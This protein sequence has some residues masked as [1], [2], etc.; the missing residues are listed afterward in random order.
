MPET[1]DRDPVVSQSLALYLLIAALLLVLSLGWAL[2]DEFFGLRPWKDYQRVFVER[3]ASFLARE[4]PRQRAAEKVLEN[5]AEYQS[6]KQQWADLQKTVTPQIKEINRQSALVEDRTNAVLNVLTTA[7]AYVGSE[8][9]LIEHISNPR[10]KA[11]RS[12]RLEKYKKGPFEVRLPGGPGGRDETLRLTF[13]QL[14]N[15]FALLQQEKGKLLLQKAA[16]LKPVSE[17]QARLDSYIKDHS[18]GLTVEALK[19]LQNKLEKFNIE[20]RQINNP[21]MGVVDRC[22]SCHVGIREPVKLTREDMGVMRG[23]K[24]VADEMSGAFTSHPDAELLTIHDPEKFGCTPC[25]GGNGMDIARVEKAHGHDEHWLW[26]LHPMENVEAGCQQCHTRDMVLDH[27]PTLTSGK[28]LFMWRGCVGCHRFEGY[29]KEPEELASTEREIQQL[30]KQREQNL[31]DIQKDI[32]A[33]DNAPDNAT[34][35]AYYLKANELQVGISKIDLQ[36]DGLSRRTKYLM[37]DRKK[38]GPDLKDV[39]AKLRPEWIPI[40]LKNPHAFRPTTR[41]PRFRLDEDELQAVAAFIWQDALDAKAPPQPKG[42]PVKGKESF[43]TRGCLGCHSVG[44]GPNLKGGWFAANLS[45]VGEKANY[46]YL[47]RWIHNPRER[48]APY[49]PLEKRDLTPDDY[50]KHGLPY[51]FDLDHSK[52]PNDGHELQV[53]QMTPMPNLRLSW[54]ESRDIASYLMTLKKDDPSSYPAAPYLT[55]AKLK[56]KGM[57]VVRRYGCAGCH[58][59][60]GMEDEGRIGTELTKEG[61]K[62][63][64]QMDFALYV[65]EAKKEGWWSHKGFFEHKLSRPE[66]YDDGMIKAEG[67]E[68]KMPDFFEPVS[69]KVSKALPE[70]S[71][72]DRQQVTQLTTFLMGAVDSQYPD[73]YFYNPGGAGADIQAGWWVVK[74]YNCEGCHQFTLG[75]QSVLQTLP[76]YQTPDGKGQ[77]PPRL[78][79]EGARVNPEWLARFLANPALSETDTDRDGVR[80]YL[81]LRM[82]TFYFSP[83]EI[84]ILVRFFQALSQQPLPYIPQKLEP[85]T[86]EETAMARALFT[87]EAAPCLKC[88]AIGLPAHD[89]FATAPNFLLASDRL[90]PDWVRH[91]ILDPAKI[92]PG[93]AMPSGLFRKEEGRWV[94]AGPTPPAFKASKADQADL[95]VRYLL[96]LTPQ[97]QQRLI[98]MSGGKLN[99]AATKPSTSE[100]RGHGRLPVSGAGRTL[101]GMILRP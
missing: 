69:K 60:A 66:I 90:K 74:K 97:E 20:I 11:A 75:Q 84:R 65:R 63:L 36:L 7:R 25:H 53:E 85:L 55:D 26:P 58:E 37:M 62:P 27:A 17:L 56:S 47:V 51:V 72:H 10:S 95:L 50:K 23:R 89:K 30:E 44:E 45:R 5:S 88:H 43:E 42:D 54:Q 3:Y 86:N 98:Q 32:Q 13:D 92:D 12:N 31:L 21:D 77:L 91:W 1:P 52:C 57:E 41:M 28:D 64:E 96:E 83:I 59:I 38:V 40:W 6:L 34:A 67:E 15:E 87:S 24:R 93:T 61:S 14:E 46:D 73:R 33:G 100:V 9:Y 94:F 70:L 35:Q 19:G 39:R 78:L 79:T 18:P 48:T 8:V 99:P 29:D 2:Y 80:S 68:L 71:P 101:T 76:Q 82:P 4:I 16:L 49:C 81:K 22:E